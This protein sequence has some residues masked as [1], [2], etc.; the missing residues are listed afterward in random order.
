MKLFIPEIWTQLKLTKEWFFKVIVETR[1]TKLLSFFWFEKIDFPL[2][3]HYWLKNYIVDK[4]WIYVANYS[5]VIKEEVL[6]KYK[7]IHQWNVWFYSCYSKY[8]EVL[9]EIE[10]L[11]RI[12]ESNPADIKNLE[13][14]C[15]NVDYTNKRFEEQY[16]TQNIKNFVN[17]VVK[18]YEEWKI[19]FEIDWINVINEKLSLPIWTTLKVDRIYIRKWASDY[20]SVSFYAIIPWK[21][22]KIRFFSKL[23][24]VNNIECDLI[25][26]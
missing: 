14:F 16:L 23:D 21:K 1:N 20:S 22:E 8:I 5:E 13:K 24:D 11:W 6:K 15:S 9:D 4:M 12:I 25:D 26:N 17:Y 3:R 2:N 19:S 7:T 18:N 10:R